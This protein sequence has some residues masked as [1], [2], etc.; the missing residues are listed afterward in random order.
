VRVAAGKE[1]LPPGA[2]YHRPMHALL[3]LPLLFSA[4]GADLEAAKKAYTDVD[5]GR[6]RDGAEAALKQPAALSD[7][8]T[9]YRLLGLCSAALGDT[10]DARDAFRLMLTIDREA[11]LPE[12]LSPRFTSSF[13]E[14]KGSLVGQTPLAITIV[15]DVGAGATRSLRLRIEDSVDVIA[16]VAFRPLD[17]ALSPR[18]K[19]AVELEM[20][21]PSAV[22]VDV[23]AYD[24][25]EGE[26]AV[27]HL[28]ALGTAAAPPGVGDGSAPVVAADDGGLTT[29][30]VAGGVVGAV[31]L[32]GGAA[33]VLAVLLA[34]PSSVVLKTDVAFADR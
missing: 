14:A 11:R 12:G 1:A 29:A 9:A 19:K 13:R 33:A 28:A 24:V 8:V 5:Y 26:V 34:P 4:V 32:V 7:R 30:I 6:C 22:P 17:G 20:D 25:H 31:V 16:T 3:L 23:I 18:I 15:S 10:D 27:L 2:E 21:V